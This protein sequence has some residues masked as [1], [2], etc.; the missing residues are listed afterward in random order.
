MERLTGQA[1]PGRSVRA[2]SALAR[3]DDHVIVSQ[4]K[5]VPSVSR[6]LSNQSEGMAGKGGRV[7]VVPAQCGRTATG[8]IQET[9][10]V[11]KCKE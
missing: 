4:G 3:A 7:A 8:K 1:S 2:F 10:L 5:E 9:S 6:R 11:T